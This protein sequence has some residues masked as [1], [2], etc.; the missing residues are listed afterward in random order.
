MKQ[1][2]HD[3]I[4]TVLQHFQFTGLNDRNT[5]ITRHQ[6]AEGIHSLEKLKPCILKC[7]PKDYTIRI[8]K[9]LHSGK[10][11]I[12]A[13]RQLIRFTNHR[14]VGKKKQTWNKV[15]KKTEAEWYYEII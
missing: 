4:E 7:I 11:V 2:Q 3:V 9:G 10:E 13:L 8:R 1:E 6:A 5:C 12:C 14:L 15:R